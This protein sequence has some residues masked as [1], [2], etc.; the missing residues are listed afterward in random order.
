MQS[1]KT[2]NFAAWL[3]LP[4]AL[5]LAACFESPN[6]DTGP[7]DVTPPSSY[8]FL[9]ADGQSSVDYS[10]QTARLL[11]IHDIQ[12]AARV[13]AD[14]GYALTSFAASEIL[15][16]YTHLDADSLNIRT[17]VAGG[18][19]RYHAKYAQ[20]ASGKSLHDKVSSAT[21]IGYGLN[22]QALVTLWAGQIST[23]ALDAT[24]RKKAAVYLDSNGV[25][26]SQM[27]SKVLAGAVAYHQATAVYLQEVTSK[28]NAALVSGKNYTVM[29]HNWDE[30]FGYFGAA[31]NYSDYSDDTLNIAAASYRDNNNDGKIDF[32]SE[33]N[34]SMMGRYTARRDRGLAP[35]DWSG[36][37]FK[38]FL[39]GRAL[40]SAKASA[41]EIA[42][43]R[44]I[45][46]DVWDKTYASN[47]IS[48][49]KGTKD[50]LAVDT[51]LVAPSGLAGNWSELKA[52]AVCLQ[53]NPYKKI[54]D[55]DLA[56]LHAYIGTYPVRGSG[57]AAYVAKLD[58]A[59][60]LVKS[61]Y[62]FSDA[63]VNATTWR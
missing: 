51:G 57:K 40:I 41:A 8:V 28:D 52:F 38:A 42:A 7:T 33:Y 43:Q 14:T 63:Q 12:S 59:F 37:A 25:D 48:Y 21:V 61:V 35:Q 54:S 17:S 27:I 1:L 15:K 3:V 39:K 30:A 46:V 49:I 31:V 4:A 47:V 44:A 2:K 11:L 24:K 32:R 16:Y 34:F 56:K 10:G 18:K 58:S 19:T 36:D 29:E 53:F 50:I 9:G 55:A 23:N 60:T 13:P 45:I 22:T 26:L 62:G 5:L 20:I 6:D